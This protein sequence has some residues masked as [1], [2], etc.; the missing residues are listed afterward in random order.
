MASCDFSRLKFKCRYIK[1]SKH[2][3]LGVTHW[4]FKH[5]VK[6]FLFKAISIFCVILQA[7]QKAVANTYLSTPTNSIMDLWSAGTNWS[8]APVGSVTTELPFVGDNI[9][10]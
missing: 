9:P 3:I 6:L 4:V 7:S 10:F 5:F 1:Y 8:E 2:A